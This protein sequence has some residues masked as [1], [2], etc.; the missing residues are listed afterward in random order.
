MSDNRM[1]VITVEN[2]NRPPSHHSDLEKERKEFVDQ[3][4]NFSHL[5]VASAGEVVAVQDTSVT[6]PDLVARHTGYEHR[7]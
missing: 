3:K 2:K 6:R 4:N 7:V 1:T 5:I